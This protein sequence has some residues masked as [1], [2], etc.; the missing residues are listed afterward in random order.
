MLKVRRQRKRKDR[1]KEKKHTNLIA[2]IQ[3]RASSPAISFA[4]LKLHHAAKG[5][6]YKI[7]SI[8]QYY[9]TINH[10]THRLKRNISRAVS[11]A[12]KGKKSDVNSENIFCR[13]NFNAEER[14]TFQNIFSSMAD[15][16]DV[17]SVLPK[18]LIDRQKSRS[19]SLFF[20]CHRSRFC[21]FKK[22]AACELTGTE[23]GRDFQFNL[24][25]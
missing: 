11:N 22:A 15:F 13:K 25:L 7:C 24:F 6:K 14:V 19:L 4:C 21:N 17:I 2:R 23:K 5:K 1:K 18:K 12:N 20:Y 9:V 16:R 3:A 10:A 8:S